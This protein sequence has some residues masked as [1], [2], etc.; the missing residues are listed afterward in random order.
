M[1]QSVNTQLK[2]NKLD[3]NDPAIEDLKASI[4]KLDEQTIRFK[5][6]IRDYQPKSL[7]LLHGICQI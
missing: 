3:E 4:A 6:R 2:I 7:K 1:N 5:E